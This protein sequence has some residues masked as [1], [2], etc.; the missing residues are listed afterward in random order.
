MQGF[1]DKDE[2]ETAIY[3]IDF[4]WNEFHKELGVRGRRKNIEY[5]ET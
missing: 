4:H 1:S 5:I 3:I 2:E